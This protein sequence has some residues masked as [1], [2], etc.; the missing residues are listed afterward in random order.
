MLAQIRGSRARGHIACKGRGGATLP[1][2]LKHTFTHAVPTTGSLHPACLLQE[3]RPQT[4]Y[5]V[6]VAVLDG[7][8]AAL[9]FSAPSD[10][11]RTP[12]ANSPPHSPASGASRGPSPPAVRRA[13]AGAASRPREPPSRE[14]AGSKVVTLAQFRQTDNV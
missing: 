6:H 3:L 10:A 11:V 2:P 9:R 14:P 7:D 5:E 1:L 4:T 13:P 12:P 8:A